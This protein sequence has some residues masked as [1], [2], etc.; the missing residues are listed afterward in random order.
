MTRAIVTARS[1][2]PIGLSDPSPWEPAARNQRWGA[3]KRRVPGWWDQELGGGKGEFPHARICRERGACPELGGGWGWGGRGCKL[4]WPLTLG[5][6]FLPAGRCRE[7]PR[8]LFHLRHQH[9]LQG[10]GSL[11]LAPSCHYGE[12]PALTT[13][14]QPCFL[15]HPAPAAA[16]G[17]TPQKMEPGG[18]HTCHSL[19]QD[20]ENS[21]RNKWGQH[22]DRSGV[23]MT[24]LRGVGLGCDLLER[25]GKVGKVRRNGETHPDKI[26]SANSINSNKQRQVGCK[27]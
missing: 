15:L 20:G 8:C 7:V 14:V 3:R 4:T 10:S 1:A 22:A 2:L 24:L 26:R 13:R 17:T 27:H 9:W 18:N 25:G 23:G 6:D 5:D 12:H 16:R 21:E 19:R 11:L